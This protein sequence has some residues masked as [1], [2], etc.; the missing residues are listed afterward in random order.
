M[1]GASVGGTFTQ[2]ISLDATRGFHTDGTLATTGAGGSVDDMGLA[3][4]SGQTSASGSVHSHTFV[5]ETTENATPSNESS[6]TH[7]LNY[8]IS[9]KTYSTTS[10]DIYYTNDASGAVS[11]TDASDSGLTWTENGTST[12][13]MTSKFSGTG[14]KGVQL[15]VDGNSRHYVAVEAKVFIQ[16]KKV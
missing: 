11:W 5:G 12:F 10:G 14:W 9:T 3:V 1:S 4:S 15:R 16:S 13:D 7:S 8:D 6:H 2:R